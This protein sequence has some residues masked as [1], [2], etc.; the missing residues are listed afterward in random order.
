MGVGS[1]L[2]LLIP[3][4]FGHN[5]AK[6]TVTAVEQHKDV[7]VITMHPEGK[8]I[9]HKSGQFAFVNFDALS[10]KETHPYTISS[11]PNSSRALN[12]RVKSLGSYTKRL[13]KKI[14]PGMK[15]RVSGPYGHFTPRQ[16]DGT[17]VWVGGGIGIT[18]FI[19]WAE[20]LSPDWATP[21]HLYY[22]VSESG[23]AIYLR[24][25]EQIAASVPNFNFTLV[26]SDEGT[27][28]TA[29]RIEFD[30]EGDL[31]QTNVYFCGPTGMRETLR[32]GL[33]A[34]GLGF[35]RFHYEEFEM[36]Q[37]VGITRFMRMGWRASSLV[38]TRLL[39]AV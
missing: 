33:V 36:R 26:V 35:N 25:F 39:R 12:F 5:S 9:K 21:T 32:H 24:A 27:R 6:Y 8:G 11:A 38:K 16:S 22:C 30:L 13:G 17:Q 23:A 14:K 18:P 34:K 31:A 29:D 15:A 20:A 4:W 19:A 28:L 3:R 37:G 2:Y 7:A 1:Y 10:L